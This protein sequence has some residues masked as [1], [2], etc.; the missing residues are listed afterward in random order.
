MH[1]VHGATRL[2]L[3]P[4]DEVPIPPCCHDTSDSYLNDD[5]NS[6]LES[7]MQPQAY[8]C[9]GSYAFPSLERS[10]DQRDRGRPREVTQSYRRG[11]WTGVSLLDQNTHMTVVIEEDDEDHDDGC[12]PPPAKVPRSGFSHNYDA[13]KSTCQGSTTLS[14]VMD[15]IRTGIMSLAADFPSLSLFATR[16]NNGKE[17]GTE[18]IM[19][20]PDDSLINVVST[21]KTST[22]KPSMVRRQVTPSDAAAI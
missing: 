21:T 12:K 22:D 1:T 9:S 13:T 16:T 17:L 15:P 20:R 4:E 8:P 3:V 18:V 10:A 2:A 11:M 14:T 19:D 6:L 5:D 7:M